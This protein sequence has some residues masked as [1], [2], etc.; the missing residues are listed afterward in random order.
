MTS[1]PSPV[2][3][4]NTHIHRLQSSS[5][6]ND[7]QISVALPASYGESDQQ[8]PVL[9]MLD[10]NWLFSMALSIVRMMYF[11]PQVSDIPEI[12]IVG[13]GY[14]TESL[15]DQMAFR[16]RDYTPTEHLESVL[17]GREAYPWAEI[18]EHSGKASAFLQFLQDDLFPFIDGQYRTNPH[19]RIGHGDSLGGLF[20]LYTLFHATKTFHH[21]LIISPSIWWDEKVALQYEKEYAEQH[22]DLDAKVFMAAGDLELLILTD[23]AQLM[24][25]LQAREYP[26]LDMTYA[27]MT[28]ETHLSIM[29]RGISTGLRALIGL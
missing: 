17:G 19:L 26:S 28:N 27:V 10:G 8:Y 16:S 18:E 4:P 21:Y 12:I 7:Y 29:A 11:T 20:M 15:A 23:V 14:N 22:D 6:D 3:I 2:A 24:I 9:Y 1:N 13:I 5:T 25:D